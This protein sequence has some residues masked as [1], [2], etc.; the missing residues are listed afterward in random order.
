MFDVIRTKG[1]RE[2]CVFKDK[3]KNQ[4]SYITYRYKQL[5]N[6]DWENYNSKKK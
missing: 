5:K 6:K 3:P 2:C 4:N 1:V